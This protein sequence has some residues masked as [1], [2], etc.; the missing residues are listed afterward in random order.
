V[1]N[2]TPFFQAALTIFAKDL[3]SEFRSRE[4]VSAMT[5]FAFLSVLAFSFALELEPMILQ[6]AAGGI[7]WVTIIFAVILGLNRSLAA[8]REQGSMD[9]ML[10]S[11]IGRSAI[12]TGKMLANVLFSFIIGV[13]LLPIASLLYGVNLFDLRIIGIIAAGTLGL[14]SVGTLLAAMTAQT[15]TRETLLPIVM[16]PTTLP[17]LMLVVRAT[18]GII[19]AQ[20]AELWAG[21][22]PV[23]LILD[24]VYLTMCVLLFPFVL[25]E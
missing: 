8:E 23:L 17:V 15:R 9:A 7:L 10:L 2:R 11:P 14:S 4:L 20:P 25:E 3:R 21:M 1:Q 16:L 24:L 22:V 5:L 6:S 18:N 12:F 19:A 13:L